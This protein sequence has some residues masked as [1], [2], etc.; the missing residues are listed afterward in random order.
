MAQFNLV[1]GGTP[2]TRI[3][4]CDNLNQFIPGDAS[5]IGDE[6]AQGMYTPGA[7]FFPA[8]SPAM[9][10]A[11]QGAV[12][13]DNLWLFAIPE[14]H[15]LTELHTKVNPSPAS[16]C[17]GLCGC[18]VMAGTTFDVVAQAFDITTTDDPLTKLPSP[19]GAPVTLTTLGVAGDVAATYH[20]FKQL[21]VPMGQMLLIGIKFAS[22]SNT[23]NTTIAML[24]GQITVSAK[25]GD[26]EV[27]IIK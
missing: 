19:V 16:E 14:M 10:A 8:Y 4:N 20:E 7:N 22:G 25:A 18:D 21:Y 12:V 13:G 24:N 3:P 11:L 1:I 15:S 17:G 23:P 27:G 9:K 2:V 5:K 6:Y 26:F